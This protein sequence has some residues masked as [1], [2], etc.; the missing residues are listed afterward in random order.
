MCTR[1]EKNSLLSRAKVESDL[2]LSIEFLTVREWHDLEDICILR[3]RIDQ[4]KVT[5]LSKIH[6][7]EEIRVI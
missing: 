4:V 7:T 5:G 6:S 1:E 3:L 2:C